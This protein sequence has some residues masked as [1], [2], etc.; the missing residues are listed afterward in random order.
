MAEAKSDKRNNRTVARG[1][2]WIEWATGGL[3][4]ILVAAMT[5]WIAY[6][7]AV[8]SNSAPDLAVQIIRQQRISNGY[9]ISFIIVNSG[10]RTAAAVPVTGELKDGDRVIETHEVTFD[11]VPAQ[12]SVTGALLFRI[13]PSAHVLDIRASG[14]VDP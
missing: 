8:N 7:A 4:A 1:A 10:A 6:H 9:E 2:H 3:C 11:Y 12:S 13:D 5:G 14:Y